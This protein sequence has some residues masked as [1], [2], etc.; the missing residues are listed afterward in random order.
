MRW[1][2][3]AY[4]RQLPN[5]PSLV[6][7]RISSVNVHFMNYMS[8]W[9]VSNH[10]EEVG[11]AIVKKSCME[12]ELNGWESVVGL[13]FSKQRLQNGASSIDVTNNRGEKDVQVH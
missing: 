13:L 8:T 3:R 6:L 11:F 9:H 4:F 1:S 7:I 5:V 12:L 2:R 10:L